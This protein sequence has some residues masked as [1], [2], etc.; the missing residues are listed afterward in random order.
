[1]DFFSL[2]IPRKLQFSK[3]CAIESGHIKQIAKAFK[4]KVILRAAVVA[5]SLPGLAE[6]KLQGRSL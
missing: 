6:Q 1:M 4:I 3:D 5:A 2:P